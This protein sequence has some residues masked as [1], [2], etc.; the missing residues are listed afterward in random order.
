MKRLTI[1]CLLIALTTGLAAQKYAPNTRW[2][3]LYENFT[4]GTLYFAGNKKTQARLNIHLWGDVLHYVSAD[5]KI[6]E[7]ADHDIVRVEIGED[8]YLYGGRQLMRL[9]AEK[10]GNVLL[11]LRA[12]DFDALNA[13]TGA[14]GASL[15]SSAATDLSSLDLGGL[16]K[17]ALAKMLEEKNSGREIPLV[18]TYYF[19]IGGRLVEAGKKELAELAGE[20]RKEEWKIFLKTNKIKWRKEESLT[21]VLDFFLPKN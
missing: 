4:E 18:T 10:G 19:I 9:V 21:K 12:G 11:C 2:P 8:A 5:G 13:G 1:A 3:Y 15:N 6:Y 16:D 20:E 17:P 14:Y 7:I